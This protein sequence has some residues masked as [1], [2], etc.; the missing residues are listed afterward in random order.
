MRALREPFHLLREVLRA[1]RELLREFAY[2]RTLACDSNESSYVFVP[3]RLTLD[4][5]AG[6]TG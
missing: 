6:G 1:L 4:T 2:L 5:A 3:A